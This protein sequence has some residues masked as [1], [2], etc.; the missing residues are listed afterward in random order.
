MRLTIVYDKK[1]GK[2][3]ECQSVTEAAQYIRDITG[4][5]LDTMYLHNRLANHNECVFFDRYVVWKLP[6]ANKP[7]P[8]P[9]K[10]QRQTKKVPPVPRKT[11]HNT[12]RDGWQFWQGCDTEDIICMERVLPFYD[13]ARFEI[14]REELG[15]FKCHVYFDITDDEYMA[16]KRTK[17]RIEIYRKLQGMT[18]KEKVEEML[19]MF[20]KT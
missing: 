20:K 13:P 15:K 7:Q 17:C 14:I 12:S 1:S 11:D 18:F 4:E 2:E 6:K 8:T 3:V 10:H 5:Q 9:P 19:K 16:R